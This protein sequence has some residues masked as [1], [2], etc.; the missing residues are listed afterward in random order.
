MHSW[1][2]PV[3]IGMVGAGANTRQKHI[4]GFRNIPGVEIVVVCNRSEVSSRAVAQEFHIPRI[5]RR[6]EEVV[7]AP[8]V[9]AVVI[10]TWP[11]LHAEVTVAALAHKKHV[12]TEAR[13]ASTLQ[14]AKQMWQ[15]SLEHPDVVAQVVPAPMSLDVDQTVQ[16]LL[17]E[18]ALG[19]LREILVTHASGCYADATAPLTWRQDD[20]LSGI[21]I[22]ALGIVHEIVQRWLGQD[23]L[24]V[25][26]DAA[27]FT[28]ER[29]HPQTGKNKP[30]AIP[31]SLSV[32]GRYP[33]GARLL[34][35][36]SGVEAGS[37]RGE[38]RL[39]GSKACLRFDFSS[40]GLYRTDVSDQEEHRLDIPAHLKRGWRVE[41][42][43][44]NSIRTGAPV[45]FTSFDQGLRYM[46]F[47]DAVWNSWKDGGRRINVRVDTRV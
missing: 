3:R 2:Q 35:H 25:S 6:W 43:F 26:A 33:S 18:G 45:L 28:T 46:T 44:I 8:D 4:P 37:G 7:A 1:V 15:A 32:L 14:E 39:N 38:I 34:Y 23:P 9:D 20:E 24:W 22:L 47:V 19:Q 10:G 36:L 29:V 40:G 13:M 21:N 42:D 16:Q 31:E 11:Y 17:E 30:V 27:I 12:L 5:A 41:E